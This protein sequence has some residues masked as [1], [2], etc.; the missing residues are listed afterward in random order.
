MRIADCGIKSNME[1]P[2][3]KIEYSAIRIPKSA[4]ELQDDYF[5]DGLDNLLWLINQLKDIQVR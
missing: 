3:F 2:K 1:N 5:F 4:I